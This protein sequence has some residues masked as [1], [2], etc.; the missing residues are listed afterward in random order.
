MNIRELIAGIEVELEA[1]QKLE[2]KAQKSI[3]VILA[4]VQQ[5]GRPNLTPEEDAECER[6]DGIREEAK[7]QQVGIK[8]KL[9]RARKAE[10]DELEAENRLREAEVT[11]TRSPQR[12]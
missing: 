5:E 3:E 10:A 8:A 11:V 9:A 1:A 2:Q 4:S 6:H 7:A 12:R